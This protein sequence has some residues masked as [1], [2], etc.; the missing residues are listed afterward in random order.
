M[1]LSYV[2]I[3]RE[4]TAAACVFMGGRGGGVIFGWRWLK[5]PFPPSGGNEAEDK[6]WP[7][8]NV[9]HW[10]SVRVDITP[11][12][13]FVIINLYIYGGK[14]LIRR[15]VLSVLLWFISGPIWHIDQGLGIGNRRPANVTQT[16]TL[17]IN[18]IDRCSIGSE[19]WNFLNPDFQ[20]IKRPLIVG[21]DLKEVKVIRELSLRSYLEYVLIQF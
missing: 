10:E 19:I 7:V 16:L 6:Q 18:C 8:S 1:R 20:K 9:M 11:A 4:G 3:T 5:P 21:Y 13:S 2:F 17:T 15:R 14:Y 12:W